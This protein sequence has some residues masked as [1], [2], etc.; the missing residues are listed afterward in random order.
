MTKRASKSLNKP[1][2]AGLR[3]Q[4]ESSHGKLQNTQT[5]PRGAH[6]YN[7]RG[8]LRDKRCWGLKS[9][10]IQCMATGIRWAFWFASLRSKEFLREPGGPLRGHLGRDGVKS[11]ELGRSRWRLDLVGFWG[12]WKFSPEDRWFLILR[13]VGVDVK[14]VVL[15]VCTVQ[16]GS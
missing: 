4:T 6:E 15:G 2:R 8:G 7:L 9:T 10:A 1:E 16:P 5:G 11:R 3:I 14:V 12:G 13:L